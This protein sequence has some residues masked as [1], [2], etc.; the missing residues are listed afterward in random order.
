VGVHLKLRPN[1]GLI[2]Y[3]NAGKSTL[4]K[5]LVPERDVE[6]ADY[7][8]TTTRPQLC[9]INYSTRAQRRVSSGD[10]I[11]NLN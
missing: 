7:A 2:G 4:M 6:I 5:A 9:H 11:F 8:F 1:I 3:P 10:F